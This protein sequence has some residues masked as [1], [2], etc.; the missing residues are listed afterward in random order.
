MLKVQLSTLAVLLFSGASLVMAQGSGVSRAFA[1][2]GGHA[3][4]FVEGH[5]DVCVRGF[6]SAIN[7][8]RAFTQV[9][10]AGHNGGRADVFGNSMADGGE[11]E[12]LADG[13]AC[14]GGYSGSTAH[15]VTKNGL[16][17]AR[18]RAYSNG[19][20]EAISHTSAFSH[21]GIARANGVAE[22]D[23]NGGE[24]VS[25]NFLHSETWNGYA[26][27]ESISRS[28]AVRGGVAI[29]ES[30]VVSFSRNGRKSNARFVSEAEAGFG[31]TAISRGFLHNV[32]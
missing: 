2:N 10:G 26:D 28:S 24:A 21:R 27:G 16:S 17:Y 6:A 22:A 13:R 7:D 32:R 19:N 3:E 1:M 14:N 5:G 23:G 9:T 25:S 4:S 31:G 15:A 12:A 20:A 11:A 30:D 18:D 29:A 8:G